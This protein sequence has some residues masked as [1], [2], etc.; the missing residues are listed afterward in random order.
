MGDD[1]VFLLIVS[2]VLSLPTAYRWVNALHVAGRFRF[3][4]WPLLAVTPLAGLALVFVVLRHWADDEVRGDGRY[5]TLLL[6][7]GTALLGIVSHILHW[8]GLSLRH[9]A[10]ERGN[11]AA[12]L[13][14]CGWILGVMIV[15]SGGNIGEGPSLW[16][17]VF[18]A[19][20]GTATLFAFWLVLN[21]T[22]KVSHTITIDRD[23]ASGL[24]I[25]AFILASGIVFGRALAGT[26]QSAW[27]AA[28]DFVREGWIT[29]AAL[30]IAV[31]IE[32]VTRPTPKRPRPNWL[33]F[34]ALPA[35]CYLVAAL[36]W[37]KWL[38]P[39]K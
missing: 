14:W 2:A 34:G 17:N 8:F 26:W 38:G 33:S 37:V 36:A 5:I 7:V 30:A 4:G 16:N 22:A 28:D 32:F 29:V 21:W 20:L 39:W 1:E 10:A 12:A 15:F 3:R 11:L 27:Q 24:R 13:A 23:V 31:M 35:A 25:G 9:D 18:S 19:A 6:F